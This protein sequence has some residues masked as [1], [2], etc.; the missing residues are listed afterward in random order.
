MEKRSFLK[1]VFSYVRVEFAKTTTENDERDLRAFASVYYI[2]LTK[3]IRKTIRQ[4][5]IHYLF[6][7]AI[8]FTNTFGVPPFNEAAAARP[9]KSPWY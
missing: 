5:N 2:L 1:N 8:K 7:I 4:L 6:K 9:C 3:N